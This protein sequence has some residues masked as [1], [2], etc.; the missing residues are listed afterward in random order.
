MHVFLSK[1]KILVIEGLFSWM[2]LCNMKLIFFML[3]G[4]LLAAQ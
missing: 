2:K 3:K 1:L 4:S